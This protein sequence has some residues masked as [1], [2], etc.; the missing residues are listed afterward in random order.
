MKAAR[1][2]MKKCNLFKD[3]AQKNNRNGSTEFI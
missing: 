3:L 1:I 2:D